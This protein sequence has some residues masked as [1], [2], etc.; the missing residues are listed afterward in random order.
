[1]LEASRE[2]IYFD[3]RHIRF[4]YDLKENFFVV[5]KYGAISAFASGAR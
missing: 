4:I 5:S 3:Y 1:M 2:L